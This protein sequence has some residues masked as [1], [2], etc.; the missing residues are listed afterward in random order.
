MI[1]ENYNY[2]KLVDAAY[3][4]ATIRY[5]KLN[6]SLD[7]KDKMIDLL[8]IKKCERMRDEL[9]NSAVKGLQYLKENNA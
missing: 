8:L 4:N 2:D 6:P 1:N 9:Y 3:I 7:D 5:L